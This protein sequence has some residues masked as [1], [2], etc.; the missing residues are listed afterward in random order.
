MSWHPSR[1][2]VLVAVA[3]AWMATVALS[4]RIDAQVVEVD[5]RSSVFHE[6][7]PTSAM[8]VV[9]PGAELSVTPWEF[10]AVNL[11]W[12]ADIVSGASEAL[13][14][15]P[16]LGRPD[17]VSAATVT[18]FR[19]V[20]SGG[21]T[22]QRKETRL[23]VGYS[24]GVERDY[25]SQAITV[26]AGSDFFQRNT[27]IEISYSHA[28]DEVCNQSYASS[29]SPTRRRPLDSSEGCFTDSAARR[30]D[31][32]A[33]DNFQGAWTQAWTPILATQVVVTGSLQQGFLGNPYRAVVLAASGESAQENHPGHRARGAVALRA[34]LY[35]RP[36]ETAF[37]FGVRGYRDT[38]DVLSQTYELDAERNLAEWLRLRLRARYYSQSGALFWSDDY[39]G[40]E[41]VHGPRG[42][43]WSGDRELSPSSSLLLGARATA[44]A[45]GQKGDRILGMFLELRS[46]LGVDVIDTTL[47]DFTWAGVEPDDTLAVVGSL[48]VTALF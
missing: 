11:G 35:V 5:L 18:D 14:A 30:T 28:F 23:G 43:Y 42:Q 15:G 31:E 3:A 44:T 41:P 37:G 8:T 33:Q 6:P 1:Y 9:A 24:H 40:G 22:L 7:S 26:S 4:R 16:V 12:E 48:S 36:L 10:L 2:R 27:Q 20:V 45:H 47:D 34:K 21:A 25:R 32:V 38:W 29:L 46:G 39:T 13:K 17:V 19:N